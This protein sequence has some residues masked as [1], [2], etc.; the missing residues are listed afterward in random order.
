MMLRKG[1]SLTSTVRGNKRLL[2]V[3]SDTGEKM[4]EIHDG[5][6]QGSADLVNGLVQ[7]FTE[8][9]ANKHGLKAVTH[10]S[11]NEFDLR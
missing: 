8:E 1:N 5:V 9:L 2:V 3:F 4:G 7:K 6:P 10:G 11:L